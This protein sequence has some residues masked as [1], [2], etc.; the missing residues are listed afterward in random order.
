MK[1]TE[2]VKK[3]ADDRYAAEEQAFQRK[4][5]SDALVKAIV[6]DLDHSDVDV[7]SY[8]AEH[9]V[10]QCMGDI[11]RIDVVDPDKPEFCVSRNDAKLGTFVGRDN[12]I[13]GI[14]KVILP[15]G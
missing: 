3:V 9:A 1:L 8:G 6:G 10:F 5:R 4:K 14:A 12:L 15:G 7:E 13:L 11:Y 2:A